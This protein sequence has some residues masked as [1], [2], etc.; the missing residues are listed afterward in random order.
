MVG[1]GVRQVTTEREPL[2]NVFIGDGE[3]IVM[4]TGEFGLE[5]YGPFFNEYVAATWGRDAFGEEYRVMHLQ[6]PWRVSV[7]ERQGRY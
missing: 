1:Q 6:V 2:G 7:D 3:Y 5:I 4:R